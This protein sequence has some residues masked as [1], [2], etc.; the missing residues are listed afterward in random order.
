M[1]TPSRVPIHLNAAGERC[2]AESTFGQY[3]QV[4]SAVYLQAFIFL[5]FILLFASAAS[6]PLQ[7]DN[8]DFPA[9][10]AQ[11]AV[12]GIPVYYRG[13]DNPHHLGIYHP[14]LY[15]YMLAAWINIFG[16]GEAQVRMFG[17]VCVFLQGFVVLEILRTL[18][19]TLLVDRCRV[20]FWT[21]FLLNPYR[22]Y[23]E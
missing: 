14:P 7:L 10:A 17:M 11:T 20:W 1:T 18:F 12:S 4:K 5:V 3:V 9:V 16:Y 6:K 2:G 13:E 22:V 21:I 8:M 15:I 23:G 19:G